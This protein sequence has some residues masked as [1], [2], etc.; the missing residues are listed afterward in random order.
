MPYPAWDLVNINRYGLPVTNRPFLLTLTARGCPYPCKFCAARTLYGKRPRLRS[1]QKIVSE[2]KYVKEHYGVN[3]F[4]FWA[5]NA[6][7]DKQH[8]YDISRGLTEALPGVRWVCNGRA[9]I[10]EEELLKI[11]K[12]SG[13]WMIGYGIEAGTKKVLGLMDKRITIGDIERAVR[14]TKKAGLEVT[15]HVMI[16]FPGETREDILETIKLVKR[17]GLDYIQPYC[18]VPFPGSPLYETAK[19]EGWIKER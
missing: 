6:I 14:L 12:K 2:M 13:C 19:N 15:G 8:M 3:D 11:M 5:E 9:D 4:L 7:S 18:A 16:G 17:L 10:I 1:W